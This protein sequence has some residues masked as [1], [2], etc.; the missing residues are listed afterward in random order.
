[1]PNTTQRVGWCGVATG[2]LA[3]AAGVVALCFATGTQYFAALVALALSV[4][5]GVISAVVVVSAFNVRRVQAEMRRHAVEKVIDQLVTK[6]ENEKEDASQRAEIID[7]LNALATTA[8]A[9]P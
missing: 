8:L 9:K 2:A 1:M 4:G 6:L 5:W 3:A 7:R